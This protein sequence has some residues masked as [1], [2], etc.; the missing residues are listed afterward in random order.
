MGLLIWHQNVEISLR[1]TACKKTRIVKMSNSFLC[2]V[3]HNHSKKN[4]KKTLPCFF[5]SRFPCKLEGIHI[6]S[7]SSHFSLFHFFFS[8]PKTTKTGDLVPEW[9]IIGRNKTNSK[10]CRVGSEHARAVGIK[11]FAGCSLNP[12]WHLDWWSEE[13]QVA[14][15]ICLPTNYMATNELPVTRIYCL[16]LSQKLIKSS[17]LKAASAPSGRSH[18]V[19][20]WLP[21]KIE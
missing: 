14:G 4:T 17:Q 20:S 18:S 11:H 1:T 5:P 3:Q 13:V 21:I 12:A 9:S 19:N 10:T 2:V 7:H 16:L 6:L 15:L 8:K